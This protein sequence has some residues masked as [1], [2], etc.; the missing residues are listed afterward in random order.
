M[1]THS[2]A[3]Y[4]VAT[5]IGNLEDL[6]P[7]AL[8][9]LQQV[10]LVAA[11]DTRHS[12]RLLRHFGISARLRA[13]H[14]HNEAQQTEA[15]VAELLGGRSVAL[16]SDAGTPL[17]SD[18]GARLVA[19]AAQ[20]GVR[21]VPL[22]G[23]SAITAALSVAGLGADR[24]VFEGFL[25]ARRSQRLERIRELAQEPRTLVMFEAP[26]R[27]VQALED[28]CEVCGTER[29]AV[30]ARE[31]SKLHETVL[32]GSLAVLL[33]RAR[34]VAARGEYVLVVAGA[35]APATPAALE[36]DRVLA[37]LLPELPPAR[38][39]RVAARL[40]GE[41]RGALYQRALA[42]GGAEGPLPAEGGA[43]DTSGRES[44][45]DDRSH[46]AEESPGSE[47]QGAR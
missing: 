15:L 21:C 37:E 10:D 30:L 27:I 40:T 8:R 11:A 2:A 29:P 35:A 1:D 6:S 25:P 5:P 26:H 31:L 17:L 19:A 47:G 23:A 20:A 4:V 41:P 16:V 7:R 32:H 28:W 38:A 34:Q 24:F 43:A 22:P 13:L 3:L 18:P 44:R 33:E 45:P 46:T 36:A 42:L 39:A 12:G 9:V 14:Q